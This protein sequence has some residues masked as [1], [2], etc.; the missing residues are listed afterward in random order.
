MARPCKV[1]VQLPEVERRV[2]WPELFSMARAAEAV[3]VDSLWLGDHLLYDLPNGRDPRSMGGVDVARRARGGDGAG[4]ARAARRLDQ[5][6]CSGDARQAGGHRRCDLRRA[7]DPR[8][9][10]RMERARV[11]GVRIPV[12]PPR[13]PVRRV[14]DRDRRTPARWTN[15]PPRRVLRPRELRAR[16]TARATGR[17]PADGRLD[18][19]PDALDRDAGRRRVER[20][21]EPLRQLGRRVRRVEGQGRRGDRG[22]R[23]RRPAAWPRRRACSCN[24]PADRAA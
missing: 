15:R 23:A 17:A 24:S 18:R 16:P 13:R 12:R 20:V 4:R 5:L 14:A 9:R 6:P 11:P 8:P 21:V 3:G 2:A 1:G 22:G 7:A 10:C 19:S